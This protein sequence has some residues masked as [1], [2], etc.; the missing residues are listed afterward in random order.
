MASVA[1]KEEEVPPTIK[2]ELKLLV[3]QTSNRVLFAEAGKDVAD[4]LLGLACLPLG[5]VTRLVGKQLLSNSIA[6][7][8]SSL[9]SLPD[10]CLV[11]PAV[12]RAALLNPNVSSYSL[13]FLENKPKSPVDKK[14]K[15]YYSCKDNVTHNYLTEVAS[16]PCPTCKSAMTS[17][18]KVLQREEEQSVEKAREEAGGGYVQGMVSYMVMDDLTIVPISISSVIELLDN[19]QDKD[20]SS[21]YESTVEVGMEEGLELLR[22]SMQSRTVLTDVFLPKFEGEISIGWVELSADDSTTNV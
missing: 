3:D 13:A 7:L 6:S 16:L 18:L 15:I 10:A 11:A 5:Y 19:F 1:Q 21:L 12:D 14:V 8:Y 22:V 9:E 2:L 20:A 17:E 4:F